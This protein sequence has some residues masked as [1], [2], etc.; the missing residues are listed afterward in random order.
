MVIKTEI[1]TISKA[2]RKWGHEFAVRLWAYFNLILAEVLCDSES[3]RVE[4]WRSS[5]ASE[6]RLAVVSLVVGENYVPFE[7]RKPFYQLREAKAEWG[8]RNVP[9]IDVSLKSPHSQVTR[10]RKRKRGRGKKKKRRSI[11]DT[12]L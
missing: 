2:T 8:R 7:W 10:K 11:S 3:S 4:N 12:S 6:A 1:Q 5:L 9:L